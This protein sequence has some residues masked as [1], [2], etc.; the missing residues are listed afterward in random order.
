MFSK[1]II[2]QMGWGGALGFMFMKFGG[3]ECALHCN[4]AGT[5]EEERTRRRRHRAFPGGLV[6]WAGAWRRTK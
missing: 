4:V 6:L 2:S 1:A 3:L 5:E